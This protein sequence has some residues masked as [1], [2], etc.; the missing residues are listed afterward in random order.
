MPAQ[1]LA[2][3]VF[4]GNYVIFPSV[5]RGKFPA[6]RK[7]APSA[8]SAGVDGMP[9]VNRLPDLS[10]AAGK[11]ASKSVKLA[12]FAPLDQSAQPA[13]PAS[14][15]QALSPGDQVPLRERIGELLKS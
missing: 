13:Q 6:P 7:T 8:A 10:A 4:R 5:A 12:A 2:A 15:Q 1:W 9:G 3:I 14:H 11:P